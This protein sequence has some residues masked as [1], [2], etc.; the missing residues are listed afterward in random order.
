MIAG[1]AFVIEGDEEV[2]EVVLC[3]SALGLNICSIGIRD[4]DID[5]GAH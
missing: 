1:W 4:N 5:D 3:V 2:L